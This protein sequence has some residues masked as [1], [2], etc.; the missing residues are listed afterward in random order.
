MCFDRVVLVLL[1]DVTGAWQQLVEYSRV[2]GRS[3]GVDFGRRWA[4]L[5]RV[6]EE[7]AGRDEILF[8]GHKHVDD[9]AGTV[10]KAIGPPKLVLELALNAGSRHLGCLVCH[11]IRGS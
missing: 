10:P 8:C 9:L 3:V 11:S 7:P 4:V 1:G 5:Q 2:G 6:G